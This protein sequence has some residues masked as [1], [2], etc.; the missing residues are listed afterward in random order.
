MLLATVQSLF[1]FYSIPVVFF[2]KMVYLREHKAVKQQ[3][4]FNN[5]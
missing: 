3:A 2:C 1:M 5:P 4:K